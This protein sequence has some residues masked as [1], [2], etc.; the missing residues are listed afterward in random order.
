MLH[1]W[2]KFGLDKAETEFLDKYD[3]RHRYPD[4]EKP[5]F[6]KV[7]CGKVEFLGMVRGKNDPIYLRYKGWLWKLAPE[8][9]KD[10]PQIDDFGRNA[11][12]LLV[13]TE[14]ST[15]WKHLKAAFRKLR[16]LGEYSEINVEFKEYDE[17]LPMGA[18]ELLKMCK[19]MAKLSQDSVT[20][21]IFDSDDP[22]ITKEVSTEGEPY[23]NW[24][25]NVF[26]MA[27][28]TPEHRRGL[29]GVCIEHYYQDEEITRKDIHGRRL[30][31]SNEF[32]EKTMRHKSEP[33]IT[34]SDGRVKDLTKLKR[35]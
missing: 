34:T 31:L 27:L 28:L 29:S 15:D 7:V 2:E 22:K 6:K 32:N 24:G 33:G 10:V 5:S 18:G 23:K 8:L 35:S 30:Y 16:A 25:N 19:Q 17:R 21:F 1:A 3:S 12:R 9:V 4:I 14:G 20:I 11:S 13:I 26:S